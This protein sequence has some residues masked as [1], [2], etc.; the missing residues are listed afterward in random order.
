MIKLTTLQSS[1][2]G[3]DAYEMFFEYA[4]IPADATHS[5]L[6][7]I[8]KRAMLTVQEAADVSLLDCTLRLTISSR[9]DDSPIRLYQ[10][11]DTVLSV[12]D[13]KGN[14]LNFERAGKFIFVKGME[15]VVIEY[16]T[17]SLPVEY[18]KLLPVAFEYATELYDGGDSAKL[19]QI[20]C[21]C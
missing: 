20:L 12:K 18:E 8:L 3:F 10:S 17:K 11:V 21:Q 4:S 6:E 5:V 2:P 13:V 1:E 7:R 15:D 9:E 14:S 16:T 19:A